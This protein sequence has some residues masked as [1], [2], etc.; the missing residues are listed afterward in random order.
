MDKC[1]HCPLLGR[2]VECPAHAA[3]PV[4][5]YCAKVDPCDPRFDVR[6][7]DVIEAR[8]RGE[9][10]RPASAS[11]ATIAATPPA[12]AAALPSQDVVPHK[13]FWARMQRAKSCAHRGGTVGCSCQGLSLCTLGK[14][15]DGTVTMSD[16]LACLD[17]DTAG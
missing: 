3:V 4:P 5:L 11:P 15:R 9:V 7:I 10:H 16:C 17:A 13:L 14:G 8:A 2:D 1:A 6:F 12:A